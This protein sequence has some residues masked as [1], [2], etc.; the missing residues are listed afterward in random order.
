MA[1]DW[2]L[3]GHHIFATARNTAKIPEELSQLANAT[4]LAVDVSSAPSVA[5][6]AKHLRL[7]PNRV[8]VLE[9]LELA[10]DNPWEPWNPDRIFQTLMPGGL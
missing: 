5:A 6:A 2:L 10:A 3:G 9:F 8:T 7:R 1:S 4:V